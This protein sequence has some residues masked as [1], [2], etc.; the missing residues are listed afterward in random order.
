MWAFVSIFDFLEIILKGL[1]K[2]KSSDENA[3]GRLVFKNSYV[4]III[5]HGVMVSWYSPL[6]YSSF[7]HHHSR[8]S[9]QTLKH[10]NQH[11]PLTY[12]KNLPLTS[13]LRSSD[14]Q[15]FING[16]TPDLIPQGTSYQE[17]D[18]AGRWSNQYNASVL[19]VVLPPPHPLSR[20]I[21]NTMTKESTSS[22][23][24]RRG[25]PSTSSRRER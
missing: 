8:P 5:D 25:A 24:E 17:S 22:E 10:H 9:W 19:P 11:I 7:C 13:R 3:T 21:R 14:W 16:W 1:L 2:K 6:S 12:T 20:L 18:K 4:K 15:C 23:R